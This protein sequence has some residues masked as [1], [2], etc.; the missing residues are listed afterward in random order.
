MTQ[1][2]PLNHR[3]VYGLHDLVNLVGIYRRDRVGLA[4]G[5]GDTQVVLRL[6]QLPNQRAHP[7]Q[8]HP[9]HEG[10]DFK[11]AREVGQDNKPADGK[12]HYRTKPIGFRERA[13]YRSDIQHRVGSHSG[14]VG[15]G[16]R[17]PTVFFQG[18]ESQV[19]PLL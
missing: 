19:R 18:S 11:F 1:L 6:L 7:G 5:A 15:A 8:D 13:A 2:P 3:L 14:G 4:G 16:K 12:Q 10:S 17:L 9:Y